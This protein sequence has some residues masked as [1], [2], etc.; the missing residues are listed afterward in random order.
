M[1][2][3][4]FQALFAPRA[5]ALIGA[6]N[7][8]G[9]V[10]R[11]LVKNLQAGG[12][13]GALWFVNPH[14][15]VIG[16]AKAYRN[17]AALPGTPDLAVIATP[18][19]SVAP[20]L[21]ELGARGARGA[22][23]ISAGDH[24]F[25]DDVLKAAR[26]HLMRIVGPNCL[27][28][29]SPGA[30]IN[31]SFAQLTPRAGNIALV[32]QSGAVATALIDWAHGRGL[33][34][35]HVLSLGDMADVDLGDA[36]DYL[37]LDPATKA[38]L[39]YIEQATSARK[40]MSAGRIA[41]RIKP[42]IV[43]K[44][45]RS[46][47]GAAAAA[48]H[49][50]A[51]AG[52]D[53][54][55]EAAFRRAGMLRVESLRDLF[56]GAEILASGLHP[57]GD[58]LMIISNGGGLGVLATDALEARHGRLA[59]LSAA[60]LKALDK[61]LPAAWSR[62]NPVDILGDAHGRRYADALDIL[63]RDEGFDAILVMNCPIGVA[64]NRE[65][66]EAL[67]QARRAY[68]RVP[69]LACWAGGASLAGPQAILSAVGV[70]T[71]EAPED[72]VR[73]F[74]H[75]VDYARNQRALLE[76]PTLAITHDAGASARVNAIIAAVRGEGRLILSEF[77]AKAV[78]EAYSIAITPIKIAHDAA[79]AGRI[80]AEF[81]ARVALKILSRDITHKSDVGGVALDLEPG[82]VGEAAR[83]MLS[84]IAQSLPHARI[85]GFTVQPMIKR[86]HAQELIIGLSV[87]PTFGPVILFGQGG[88]GVEIIA[89]TAMALPPLNSALAS[90]LIARTRVSKLLAGYRDRA[91]ANHAAIE[92]ALTAVSELAVNHPE[93]A[94][95]DINPLLADADGVIALDARIILGAD[96]AQ[97]PPL[98]IR[99]YPDA[100]THDIRLE[101]GLALRVRAL[102]PSDA[103]ALL[104]MGKRTT[105]QDLRLRFH[106]AV[107]TDNESGA[108]RLC[109]IDYDREMALGAIEGDGAL[110]G[111]AR[112]S[113]DPQFETGEFAILVRSD[114]QKRGIGRALL[115]DILTYA[116]SR[117]VRRVWGDVLPDNASML[118]FVRELGATIEA[119][120]G[121]ERVAFALPAQA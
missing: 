71:F 94:E 17:V 78:L 6:S 62:A 20:L 5:I 72:G 80:A 101:D 89:D 103:S 40:F 66:A 83:E 112:I 91:P 84:R 41:S 16:G 9:S 110:A 102:A 30:G 15:D 113:F 44:A 49:T 38:I 47:A 57:A 118:A 105:P 100:L 7:Q 75:L 119:H 55:Y 51:L 1:T 31:A 99:P 79:D 92:Q 67:A 27:G 18:A 43:V 22:I 95:L 86:G 93:I 2:I 109:Q 58:R 115:A 121:A 32:T 85:D 28:L 74:S 114:L 68:P 19:Q 10:G 13:G 23:I 96:G 82:R 50:G 14:D 42:V 52:A 87:D 63:A 37:A 25:R 35:S 8:E 34:F 76:T 116:A 88:V 46:A 108:A 65:G 45:G 117:G 61:V 107:R 48:S 70:P 12:F 111:V 120:D 54:V 98:A 60:S 33:G 104:E 77:E 36:L 29:L 90:D 97:R 81:G 69:F 11:V 73:A 21:D 59:A 24:H 3:R 56:D 39:L 26:P 64:D 4:N 53:A 106:G